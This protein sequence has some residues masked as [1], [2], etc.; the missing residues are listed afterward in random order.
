MNLRYDDPLEWAVLVVTALGLIASI[1]LLVHWKGDYEN[2][3]VRPDRTAALIF[4]TRAAYSS[5]KVTVL[6]Q[7][8]IVTNAAIALFQQPPPPSYYILDQSAFS[9]IAWM[10]VS[11]ILTGQVFRGTYLRERLNS[12]SYERD[13]GPVGRRKSDDKSLP[14]GDCNN[15]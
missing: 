12:G 13:L 4:L 14:N 5:T 9:A 10:V 7:T 2:A 3:K 6:L 8:I 15:G 1:T 11:I